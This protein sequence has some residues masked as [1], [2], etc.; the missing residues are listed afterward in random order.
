M[1]FEKKS[2]GLREEKG[3]YAVIPLVCVCFLL[4]V[5]FLISP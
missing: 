5:F 1:P 4:A 2:G 3:V